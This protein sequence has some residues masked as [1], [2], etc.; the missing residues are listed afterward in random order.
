MKRPLLLQAA[1]A[2]LVLFGLTFTRTAI[3]AELASTTNAPARGAIVF[4]E[5]FDGANALANWQGVTAPQI[6][7]SPG[8]AGS[9]ALV[10]KLPQ[11]GSAMIR[12][13]LPI[14]GLRGA[15]VRCR[16]LVKADDV[17]KPANAWSGI[18]VMLHIVSPAGQRWEQRNN[19]FGTFDWKPVEFTT[20]IPKEPLFRPGDFYR[21]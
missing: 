9:T 5:D 2:L 16:A 14:E 21:V 20:Q 7:L 12:R 10:V 6:Q 19:V 4:R 17:T 1:P 8:S 11:N 3:G 13:P 18:K 15:K